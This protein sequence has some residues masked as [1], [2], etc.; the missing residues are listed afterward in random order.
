MSPYNDPLMGHKIITFVIF[1]L[2]M[3]YDHLLSNGQVKSFSLVVRSQAVHQCIL[4]SEVVTI[5]VD[6]A[7]ELPSALPC[8]LMVVIRVSRKRDL[9]PFTHSSERRQPSLHANPPLGS[10]LFLSFHDPLFIW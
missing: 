7:T 9:S 8:H 1:S 3:F 2:K 10:C 6:M 5:C 4:S